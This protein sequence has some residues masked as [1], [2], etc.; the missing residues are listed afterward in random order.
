MIFC[1]IRDIYVGIDVFGRGCYGGGGFASNEALKQIVVERKNRKLSIAIFA[2]GWT[3]ETKP[4]PQD[5]CDTILHGNRVGCFA[6]RE[7]K[8]WKLLEEFLHFRGI[9][10]TTKDA[11]ENCGPLFET[12]FNSGS[13]LMTNGVSIYNVGDNGNDLQKYTWFLNLELQDCLPV[14]FSYPLPL[15]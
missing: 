3:H 11:N 15:N 6:E 2:P 7:N 8:F 14:L 4:K 5:Q 13:G 1:R 10:L 9:K 12:S